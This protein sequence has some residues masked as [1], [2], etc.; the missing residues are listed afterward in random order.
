MMDYKLYLYIA[1]ALISIFVYFYNSMLSRKNKASNAY[2]SLDVMLKKRYDLIPNLVKVVKNYADFER[3]LLNKLTKLR[4]D[5]LNSDSYREVFDKNIVMTNTINKI[6]GYA[7]NNPDLKANTNYLNLQK[8]LAKIEDQI[9]AARRTYNAHV[10]K[11][12]NF[13]QFFPNS[14]F[15]ML[16]GFKKLEWFTFKEDE[17]IEVNID[18]DN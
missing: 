7:E 17:K 6:I 13:I 2:A 15:A 3:D 12:N 4:S 11:Y 1:L 18:E 10:T 8:E 16:F 5:L 9:S 14:V